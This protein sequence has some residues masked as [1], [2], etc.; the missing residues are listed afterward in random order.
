[1]YQSFGKDGFQSAQY[2]RT[3]LDEETGPCLVLADNLQSIFLSDMSGDGLADLVRVR[4]SEVCYW[5]NLGYGKFGTKITMDNSPILDHE[6]I[7]HGRRIRL[8]DIDGSGTTD[9]VYL[10]SDGKLRFCFNASGN[11]WGDVQELHH[12][13]TSDD[14]TSIQLVDLMGIG[15]YLRCLVVISIKPR[16]TYALH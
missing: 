13:P 10:G 8:A 5:P 11:A 16:Y 4:V 15:H 9:L 6:E 14:L 1:M 7:F 2:W 12:F 3:P